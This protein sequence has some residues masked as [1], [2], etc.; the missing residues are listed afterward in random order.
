MVLQGLQLP[1]HYID[2]CNTD[3]GNCSPHALCILVH[4]VI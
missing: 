2:C 4:E 1:D 3:S